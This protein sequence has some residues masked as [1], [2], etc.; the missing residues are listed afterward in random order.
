MCQFIIRKCPQHLFPNGKVCQFQSSESAGST[1]IRASANQ[2]DSTNLI[3][4]LC[5][6]SQSLCLRQIVHVLI[7]MGFQNIYNIIQFR[8]S[9]YD[10]EVRIEGF[11]FASEIIGQA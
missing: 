11:L 9:A 8:I 1:S 10:Q 4:F 6:L 5:I 7:T 2:L 3:F